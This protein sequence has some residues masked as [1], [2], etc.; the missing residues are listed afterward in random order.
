M[1]RIARIPIEIP[2]GVKVTIDTGL[3][4]MEGPKGKLDLKVPHNITVEQKDNALAVD[5]KSNE[6]Q[7]RANHGTIRAHL[8]NNLEGLTNGHK[9]ELEIQG[10]GF[11]AALQGKKIVFN[12]GFSHPVEFDVP[13]DVDVKV[14]NQT[15]MIVEGVDN[16]RV[17][18][19]AAQIRALKPVEPYKGKGIRYVG[20]NVRR[21]QGKSV[22]K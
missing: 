7:A 8:A 1:S 15:S 16:V 3:V 2:S 19:I 18:Q 12:L 22:T 6:K 11:R 14:P 5:R 17:G 4:K 9:R 20:E 13:E 10:I 21:K